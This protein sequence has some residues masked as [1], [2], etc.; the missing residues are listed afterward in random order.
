[1]L[2][3]MP[4]YNKNSFLFLYEGIFF[5]TDATNIEP[6]SKKQTKKINQKSTFCSV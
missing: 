5:Y 2:C 1:M 6:P 4:W 3:H